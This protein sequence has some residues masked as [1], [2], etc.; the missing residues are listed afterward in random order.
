VFTW[1]VM[2]WLLSFAAV[3]TVAEGED[4][5]GAI[6]AALRLAPR[7]VW[8]VVGASFWFGLAHLVA[9]GIATS[10]VAFPLAFAGVLP[11]GLVFAGLLLVKLLYLAVAAFL[12]VGRLAAYLAIVEGPDALFIQAPAPRTEP[13][14]GAD[15]RVDPCELILSDLPV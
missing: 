15:T 5:F 10:A 6:A 4:T 8:A 7:R 3:F 9:F 2:N 14:S 13:P 11:T 12:Y 1:V